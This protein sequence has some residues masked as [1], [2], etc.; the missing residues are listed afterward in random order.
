MIDFE[1]YWADLGRAVAVCDDDWDRIHRDQIVHANG[2][3]WRIDWIRF[4]S[5]QDM[6]VWAWFAVPIDQSSTGVGM[7]WLPGYSYGTPPPD[8]TCLIPGVCTLGVNVHGNKPDEAYVN[9]AGKNDYIT[10][11]IDDPSG[12]IYSR[13]AAHCL[14]AVDVLSKQAEA[15]DQKLVAAGMSQG[16]ALAVITAAQAS[17]IRL[18]FADM[19]FLA[20]IRKSLTSSSSPVYKAFR[21]YA[22]TAPDREKLIDT[23]SLFDPVRHAPKVRVPTWLSAGGRDPAVKPDSVQAVYDALGA[24]IRKFEFFPSAGHVFLREMNA[25]HSL[26]IKQYLSN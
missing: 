22:C 11:N 25:A 7:L 18:C 3:T 10:T 1:S 17:A 6:L 2:G 26:W 19:P 24:K 16:G 23:L 21:E 5:V 12:Y 4:S 8:E 9:P 13:I 14:R 20:N 15:D